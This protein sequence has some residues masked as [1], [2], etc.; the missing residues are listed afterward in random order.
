MRVTIRCDGCILTLVVRYLE[1]FHASAIE[2]N[3]WLT[4]PKLVVAP[5]IWPCSRAVIARS[6]RGLFGEAK[7]NVQSR[8]EMAS[9][10]VN[11]ICERDWQKNEITLRDR[12]KIVLDGGP[13]FFMAR[14]DPSISKF[15]ELVING[16]ADCSWEPLPKDVS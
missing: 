11:G 12:V 6:I 3:E 15:D 10:N 9:C 14:Y 13:C 1:P 4:Y 2:R 16:P 7:G 8:Q 5:P